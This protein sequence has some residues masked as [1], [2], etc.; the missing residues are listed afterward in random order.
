MADSI[1]L[2]SQITK[3][4]RINQLFA[5]YGMPEDIQLEIL[6][7]TAELTSYFWLIIKYPQQ[8]FF[9]VISARG[10]VVNSIINVCPRNISPDLYLFESNKYSLDEMNKIISV[11]QPHSAYQPL[12]VLTDMG[13][14]QFYEIFSHQ[15]SACVATNVEFQLP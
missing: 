12:N 15:G 13:I 11:V 5:E 1:S 4:Y 9:A 8:G 14:N 6:P 3:P 2:P 10:T 7:L